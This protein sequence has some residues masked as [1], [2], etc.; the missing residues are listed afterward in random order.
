MQYNPGWPSSSVNLLHVRAVGAADTLHYIWGSLGAPSV[1]LVAT[2]GGSSSLRVNWSQL[3]SPNPAGAIWMEPRSSVLYS[4]AI[5]FTK[6]FEYSEARGLEEPFLPPYDLA[7]FSWDSLNHT[8]NHTALTAQFLGVPSTDPA[9][10]FS[11]GSLGFRVTAYGAEGRDQPLPSL[12]HTANS[13][14]VEF[15]L[16]GVAPRGNS[17]LFA[18][19][20][21]TVQELGLLPRL[22]SA[23]SI[24]DE[25]TPAVF[26]TLA[27]VAESQSSGSAL[28]FLQW[29]ATAYSSPSPQRQDS[30]QCR[31]WGLQEANWSLPSSSIVQAFFGE[32]VGSSYT[33]SAINISFGGEEGAGYRE[34]LYLS[35]S[36]LLGFGQPPKDTFSPLVISIMAVA[37]AAPTLML[38]GGSCL[39]LC[40]QRQ[41]CSQYEPIN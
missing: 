9:G 31:A 21:A 17:S 2:S 18:L 1:L 37:L 25:Y 13:S 26:E 39:L 38:L 11:N 34:R 30:I 4:A 27:L 3:L 41:R 40:A 33:L 35:W 28:S 23:R 24:D 5:I 7:D 12:L 32:A 36:A 20:V 14:K 16:S 10:S 19:E 6:V 22:L 15:V 8:L 29:K